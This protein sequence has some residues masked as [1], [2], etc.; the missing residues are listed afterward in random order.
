M[1]KSPS[2]IV[3]PSGRVPEKASRLDLVVLELA[4]A[5]KVFCRLPQGF[6]DFTVFME[7]ESVEKL[8]VVPTTHLGALGPSGAPWCLVG[9]TGLLSCTSLAP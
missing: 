4:A 1:M 7:P 8:P 9:P 5:D 3:A 6:W 2:V